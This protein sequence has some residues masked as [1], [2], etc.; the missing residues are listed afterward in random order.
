MSQR[1]P[2]DKPQAQPWH[3]ADEQKP[4][5]AARKRG[6]PIGTHSLTGGNASVGLPSTGS[7]EPQVERGEARDAAAGADQDLLKEPRANVAE[8]L[9]RK[10]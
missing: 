1:T 6:G 5:P 10:P 7:P 9:G 3:A 4:E 8:I 2:S